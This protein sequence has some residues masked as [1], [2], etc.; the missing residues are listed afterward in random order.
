M[1]E[2]YRAESDYRDIMKD[3]EE[4]L[5]SLA[6]ALHGRKNFQYRGRSIDVG[7]EFEK[8]RVVEAFEKYAGVS[9]DVFESEKL[10]IEEA[11]RRGYSLGE[12]GTYDD[13]FYLIFLNEIEVKLGLEKPTILYEYP[14]SMAALSRASERDSKYAERFEL[15]IAGVEVANAFSEL[16]DADEQLRRLQ[17]ERSQRG[18]LGKA[19]YDVDLTFID[20]LRAGMPLSSGIALGV[21]RLVMLFLDAQSIEDVRFFP[22]RDL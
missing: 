21:D 20:A 18:Q 3:C 13:A 14:V 22:F 2:W 10:L 6:M 8:L 4:L 5:A 17:Q 1:L 15:Y 9:R 7:G 11:S 16:T 19:L 12:K